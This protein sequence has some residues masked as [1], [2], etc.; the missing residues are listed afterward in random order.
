MGFGPAGLVGLAETRR[1]AEE[2]RRQC[3]ADIDPIGA[4]GETGYG[5]RPTPTRCSATCPC[6]WS[7]EPIWSAKT[8]TASRLRGGIKAVLDWATTRGHRQ[9]E[10]PAR[11]RGHLENLL[12]AR[13]KVQKVRHHAALPH[14]E[15]DGFMAELKRQDGITALALRFLILTAA[16]TG[17]VLGARWEKI[18]SARG[19]GRSRPGA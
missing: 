10:N 3:L 13:T 18:D 15:I 9:G 4:R 1:L 6:R 5:W 11:W 2:C 8:E 16:R 17:E 7:L 14:P 12:P 19:P